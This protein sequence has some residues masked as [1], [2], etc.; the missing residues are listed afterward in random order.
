M[1]Q[2]INWNEAI[3][4]HLKGYSNKYEMQQSLT[5]CDSITFPF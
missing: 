1:N 5:D 3:N 2:S 4:E